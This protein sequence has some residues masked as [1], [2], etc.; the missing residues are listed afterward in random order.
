MVL[1]TIII[2]LFGIYSYTCASSSDPTDVALLGSIMKSVKGLPND[3]N[4]NFIVNTTTNITYC[5]WTGITCVLINNETHRLSSISLQNYNLTGTL[6]QYGWIAPK[7]LKIIIF[8]NNFL[9]GNMPA[10]LLSINRGEIYLDYND[11][12][13]PLPSVNGGTFLMKLQLQGNKFSGCI[14]ST[15]STM[16]SLCT[17]KPVACHGLNLE[18][19]Y[20]NCS[21][22]HCTQWL[23]RGSKNFCPLPFYLCQEGQYCWHIP[24]T[25]LLMITL[26]CGGFVVGT[27]AMFFA[28]KFIDMGSYSPLPSGDE[29]EITSKIK[30][31]RKA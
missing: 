13:G 12:S 17:S 10:E 22:V 5:S 3:W 28:A 14:P 9:S 4:S 16:N 19:N 15:W 2:L 20:L 6:P 26:M 21:N 18:N 11:F 27:L 1:S 24:P 25:I 23:P 31:T 8:S 7:F 29:K 30:T